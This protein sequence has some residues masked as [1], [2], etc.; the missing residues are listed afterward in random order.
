MS[1][2]IYTDRIGESG[3]EIIR[4][5][6]KDATSLNHHLLAPDHVLKAYASIERP[7]FDELMKRLNLEG[8]VVL[9]ALSAKLDEGYPAAEV[10]KISD[11]FRAMLTNALK[12][13]RE[14]GRA[15]IEAI[16]LL[17]G[18]FADAGNFPASMFERLGVDHQTVIK[19]I[20]DLDTG[21]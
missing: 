5:A 19:Q 2:E 13:S 12:H 7:K 8:H 6:Y 4:Q 15:R 3:R 20:R 16:D 1:L 10:M 9:Q 14:N 18:L 21:P 11:T 17:A